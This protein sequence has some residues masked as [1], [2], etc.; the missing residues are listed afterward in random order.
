[1][2]KQKP[3]FNLAHDRL[4]STFDIHFGSTSLDTINH[5]TLIVVASAEDSLNPRHLQV[6]IL[7]TQRLVHVDHAH[8]L[9]GFQQADQPVDKTPLVLEDSFSDQSK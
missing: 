2:S 3:L 9:V 5:G 8:T 4:K 7:C 1:M 6:P